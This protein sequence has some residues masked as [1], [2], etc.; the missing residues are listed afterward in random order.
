[1]YGG[2]GTFKNYFALWI[3]TH[4]SIS[5]WTVEGSFVILVTY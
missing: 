2:H 5:D 4:F 1:M 3:A